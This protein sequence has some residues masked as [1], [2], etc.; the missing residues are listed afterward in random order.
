MLNKYEEN[1][2]EY[3]GDTNKYEENTPTMKCEEIWK[4]G[5]KEYEGNNM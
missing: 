4:N 3:E 2:K 5:M 1:M